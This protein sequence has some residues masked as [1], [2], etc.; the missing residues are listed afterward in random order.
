M[1]SSA[2]ARLH[3]LGGGGERLVAQ[4]DRRE[5]R[6]LAAHHRHARGEGA[7]ASVDAVGLA[8]RHA[9][10]GV[11]DAERVGADLRHR[12]FDALADRGHAGDDFDLA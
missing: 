7:H 6:R 8:V 4:L 9:H 5:P 3:Q 11:M 10:I 2:G 1:S 12:G